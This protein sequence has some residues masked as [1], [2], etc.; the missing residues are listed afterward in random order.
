MW[1]NGGIFFMKSKVG[2]SIPFLCRNIIWTCSCFRDTMPKKRRVRTLL[3]KFTRFRCMF[4]I[5]TIKHSFVLMIIRLL[6]PFVVRCILN[7]TMPISS[8]YAHFILS[9][10]IPRRLSKIFWAPR[11]ILVLVCISLFGRSII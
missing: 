6:M 2:I 7:A 9:C 3:N 1:W 4:L 5:Y 10:K 11:S 8:L